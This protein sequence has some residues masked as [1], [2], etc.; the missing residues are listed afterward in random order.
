[1]HIKVTKSGNTKVIE[2]SDNATVA[3]AINKA[4]FPLDGSV[5]LNGE[6]IDNPHTY[7]LQDPEDENWTDVI[8]IVPKVKGGC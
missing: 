2:V 5:S 1:M 7:N 4:G 3:D 6:T 8:T